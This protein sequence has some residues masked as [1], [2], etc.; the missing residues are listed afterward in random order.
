MAKDK[1]DPN[2]KCKKFCPYDKRFCPFGIGNEVVEDKNN[3]FKQEPIPQEIKIKKTTIKPQSKKQRSVNSVNSGNGGNSGNSGNSGNGGN[4][5]IEW[6]SFSGN[7]NFSNCEL[8]ISGAMFDLQ[9][10]F[11]TGFLKYVDENGE[12]IDEEVM[13]INGYISTNDKV[14][15]FGGEIQITSKNG[16]INMTGT[17]KTNYNGGGG[18]INDETSNPENPSTQQ[19]Y[20]NR[21]S[22][23]G[24]ITLNNNVG[25]ISI[26]TS[27]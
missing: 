20:G 7:A 27:M 2:I 26:Q 16:K 25:S 13:A 8:S 12:P 24:N 10:G 22:Y 17:F 9:M 18:V 4:G 1:F 3:S 11:F 5:E 14:C 15:D 19:D 23:F 21:K 6:M